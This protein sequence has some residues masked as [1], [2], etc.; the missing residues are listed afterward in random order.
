M[1]Y[2]CKTDVS[3]TCLISVLTLRQP[4]IYEGMSTR[5]V[6]EEN[7][8]LRVEERECFM[9]GNTEVKYRFI[10]RN[11]GTGKYTFKTVY[12]FCERHPPQHNVGIVEV[13]EEEADWYNSGVVI[14]F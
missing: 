13:L 7:D 5:A 8:G 2:V 3:S 11:R 10:P 4:L 12:L 9:C 14:T 6:I 1:F